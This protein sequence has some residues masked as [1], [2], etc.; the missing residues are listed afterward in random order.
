MRHPTPAPPLPT[1]TTTTTPPAELSLEARL[2]AVEA[3][4]TIRLDE[5]AVAYE[6]HTAH[7][8]TLPV[9]LADL[10]T[11]P[12]PVPAPTPQLQPDPYPTPVAALLQRAHHRLVTGGWCG[13]ALHDDDGAL[14]LYGAIHAEADGDHGLESAALAVL[15]DTIRRT[16]GDRVDS[17]PAFNDSW[18]TG[19]IPMRTLER[20]ADVADA[21]GL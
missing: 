7:I 6:V 1:A 9:D 8:P 19:R 12:P 3:A 4:M 11:V 18:G 15:L 14:C 17:V 20:A 16:Y 13:G 2:A 5:A 21:R 10:V